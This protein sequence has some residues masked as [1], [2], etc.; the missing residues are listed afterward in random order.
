M[1]IYVRDKEFNIVHRVG[2]DPHDSLYVDMYGTVHYH[3][4]QNG[5]GCGADSLLDE[6]AVYEF[7]PMEYGNIDEEYLK[8]YKPTIR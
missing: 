3:N 4:L 6:D 7:C 2:E 5:E 8:K 1:H